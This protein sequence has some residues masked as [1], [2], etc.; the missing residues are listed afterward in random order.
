[1]DEVRRQ[2]EGG[3]NIRWEMGGKTGWGNRRGRMERKTDRE[4][5]E[6]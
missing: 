2:G 3:V 1:M 5:K 6:K 4:E